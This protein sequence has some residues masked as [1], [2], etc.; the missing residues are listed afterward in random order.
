MGVMKVVKRENS[1]S[2]GTCQKLVFASSIENTLA[3]GMFGRMS[4]IVFTGWCGLNNAE[5]VS[6]TIMHTCIALFY[7][8]LKSH[9][10]NNL[11]H[12]IALVIHLLVEVCLNY[13]TFWCNDYGD[14]ICC[15]FYRMQDKL[16]Y[17]VHELFH[18]CNMSY[19]YHSY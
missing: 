16:C 15:M 9:S 6:D 17:N 3:F 1:S 10:R 8:L 5:L 18:N 13:D 2:R 12:Q 14:Y 19:C 4:S 7:L 11:F